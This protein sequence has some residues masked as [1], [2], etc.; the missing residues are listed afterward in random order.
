MQDAKG[1][2]IKAGQTLRRIVD[3]KAVYIGLV[4]TVISRKWDEE[5]KTESL[6]ADGGYICELITKDRAKE[7]EVV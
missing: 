6:V 7:Y 4:Y 3:S 2:Q 5:D 1:T